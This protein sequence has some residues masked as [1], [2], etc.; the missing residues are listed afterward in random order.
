M[1]RAN[2]VRNKTAKVLT[3]QCIMQVR[4]TVRVTILPI[5]VNVRVVINVTADGHVTSLNETVSRR[6]ALNGAVKYALEVAARSV[7]TILPIVCSVICVLILS[8]G[9][10]ISYTVIDVRIAVRNSVV[11]L[12]RSAYQI[13]RRSL[14]RSE[15]LSNSVA[16]VTLSVKACKR[17]LIPAP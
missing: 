17:D 5:I 9:L 4:R 10:V 2:D 13:N 3:L 8:L 12:R 11:N 7:T 6:I 16:R 14:A 1:V 15:I